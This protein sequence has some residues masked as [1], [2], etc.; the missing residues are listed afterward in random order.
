MEKGERTSRHDILMPALLVSLNFV[1]GC[2]RCATTCVGMCSRERSQE[3]DCV[4]VEMETN[5]DTRRERER[6]LDHS[7]CIAS[8]LLCFS[9]SLLQTMDLSSSF[10]ATHENN[11]ARELPRTRPSEI[12]SRTRDRLSHEY[13]SFSC[14]C[15]G[16]A[17]CWHTAFSFG[18]FLG[19]RGTSRTGRSTALFLFLS[20]FSVQRVPTFR[21]VGPFLV[22]SA[23]Q[24]HLL[25]KKGAATIPLMVEAMVGRFLHSLPPLLSVVSPS[26]SF[27][28]IHKHFY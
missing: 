25:E 17:I 5:G 16:F 7:A 20:K 21:L 14:H 13:Q 15:A 12:A 8:T 24:H 18:A 11:F 10:S 23:A 3:R 19:W 26:L 27:P 2:A 9:F 28:T 4:C 1:A 6:P 22:C